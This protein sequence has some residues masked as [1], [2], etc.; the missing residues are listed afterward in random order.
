MDLHHGYKKITQD[1]W[2]D[3]DPTM[4]MFCCLDYEN[5]IPRFATGD[6]WAKTI[7]QPSLASSV[8]NQICEVYEAARGGMIYG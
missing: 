4:N 2:N 3:V 8:P 6:D 5:N 1:N 7:L